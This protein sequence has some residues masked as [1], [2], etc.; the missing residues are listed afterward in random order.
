[1][2][3][4]GG[5]INYEGEV[6]ATIQHEKANY[7]GRFVVHSDTDNLLS[8]DASVRLGLIQRVNSVEDPLYS[9]LDSTPVKCPP[10]HIARSVNHSPYS[11][12]TARRVP[13]PLMPKVKTELQRLEKAGIIEPIEEPTDWCAPIVPVLKKS[14]SVRITTD[15]KQLN[16]AV[17]RERYML[18]T[19]EHKLSGARVFSKLDAT[20]GFF[21]LPLDDESTKLTTFI[22]PFG[23]YFYR[24]PQGIT[25]APEIFQRT[26]ENI[27]K[28][29]PNT[30]SF[31]DD[32]LVFS[33][34]DEEHT[35]HLGAAKKKLRDTGLKL[36]LVKCEER[37]EIEFLGYQISEAG[38]SIHPSKV[39]AVMVSY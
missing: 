18:P 36:N 12:H 26:V 25:S 21:Q 1:M 8:R 31:F 24:L 11:V 30:V 27:L 28:D 5:N 29:Q 10:V 38:I 20:S 22:T 6:E 23:C 16:K 3:A 13:L 4:P 39:E 17:K 19:L 34:S 14:G 7:H 32:I 15:F 35:V 2:G 33:N 9:E 37:K